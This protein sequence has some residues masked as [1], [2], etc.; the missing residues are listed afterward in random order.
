M[1]TF[2]LFFSLFIVFSQS[3]EAFSQFPLITDTME[4]GDPFPLIVPLTFTAEYHAANYDAPLIH[5]VDREQN[6]RM[7]EAYVY[8][9]CKPSR[10]ARKLAQEQ[11]T[12]WIA[13]FGDSLK[14]EDSMFLTDLKFDHY[15]GAFIALEIWWDTHSISKNPHRKHQASIDS[16]MSTIC[17]YSCESQYPITALEFQRFSF[18]FSYL[19]H[20]Q[21]VTL[22]KEGSQKQNFYSGRDFLIPN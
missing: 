13:L 20:L 11:A 14:M 16:I 15:E 3:S 22:H 17:I 4:Y 5:I 2:P 19:G 7:A 12:K 21:I 1:R 8:R 18:E 6:Y 9:F 10:R